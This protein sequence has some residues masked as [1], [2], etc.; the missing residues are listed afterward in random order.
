M[1]RI[2]Q[3]IL[4]S[5]MF[6]EDYLRKCYPFLKAEYF[7]DPTDNKLFQTIAKY[8]ENYNTNPSKEAIEITLQNDRSIKEELYDDCVTQLKDLE[9]SESG[10]D[11][12]VDESEAFCK[13][14]AVYNAVTK[15]INIIEGNDKEFLPDSIPTIL[16]EALSVAFNTDIGHDYYEDAAKRFDFYNQEEERIPWK[17]DMLN[18]ITQGGPTKKSLSCFIA[19]TGGGKTVMLCDSAAFHVSIGKNVLYFSAEMADMRISE[20]IDANILDVQ[21]TELKHMKKSIFVDRLDALNKK[22]RGRLIVKEFPTASAHVGHLKAVLNELRIKKNFIPDVIYVDYLNIFLSQRYKA[23]SGA[24]SYTIIK[25]V[26][27]ELR[28]MAVEYDVPVITATQVNRSGLTSTDIDMTDTSESTGLLFTVDFLLAMIPTEELD[29]M[30]QIMLK[31]LKNRWGD[32]NIY[33]RF[34]VGKNFSKMTFYDIDNPVANMHKEAREKE[35]ST[36]NDQ[37]KNFT[38]SKPGKFSGKDFSGIKVS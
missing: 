4:S 19:P 36:K 31:Q 15:S 5:L 1:Q 11:W 29:Q 16:Q 26:A 22:S 10:L 9:P 7:S 33:K 25:A 8:I 38:P 35:T 6:N 28:G 12:I 23:S 34:T 2:E 24:N 37:F 13:R 30:D 3:T 20:R 27:E 18:K 21:V 32:I 14:Q 17:L